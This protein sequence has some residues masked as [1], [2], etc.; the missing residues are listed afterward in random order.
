M[1]RGVSAWLCGRW[2]D[3]FQTGQRGSSCQVDCNHARVYAGFTTCMDRCTSSLIVTEL[4]EVALPSHE[5]SLDGSAAGQQTRTIGWKLHTMILI[6]INL[7]VCCLDDLKQVQC[8]SMQRS[9]IDFRS[10]K[11]QLPCE[12]AQRL[13]LMLHSSRSSLLLPTPS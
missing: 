3:L 11:C 10:N 9:K 2:T 6:A 7:H 8:R 12:T 13:P 1:H 4:I 5:T